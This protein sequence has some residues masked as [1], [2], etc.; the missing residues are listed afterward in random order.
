MKKITK[1]I[2]FT[3][4]L[5]FAAFSLTACKSNTAPEGSAEETSSASIASAASEE[6]SLP[7][8]TIEKRMLYKVSYPILG[9]WMTYEYDEWGNLSVIEYA[10][11]S[12][13]Y[14]TYDDQRRLVRIDEKD[15]DDKALTAEK[16][17]YDEKDRVIKYTHWSGGTTTTEYTYD[18]SGKLIKTVETGGSVTNQYDY[19]YAEDGS[20]T[21]SSKDS[22][23]HVLVWYYTAGDDPLAQYTDDVKQKEYTY[24]ENGNLLKYESFYE[25]EVFEYE[26]YTYDSTGRLTEKAVS[27]EPGSETIRRYEYDEFG[28][29]ICTKY[30]SSTGEESIFEE[31]E[32]KLFAVRTE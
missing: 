8:P 4:T 32:Y 27:I 25:G 24:D 11:G 7:Y 14:Y 19:E 30:V 31:C 20:Y 23:G 22:E 3:L 17:E 5:C 6:T 9:D 16:W 12:R 13:S 10:S 15:G 1:L 29:C 2:A 18:D 28:N 21:K 26:S